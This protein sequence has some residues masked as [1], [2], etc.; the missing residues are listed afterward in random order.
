MLQGH[1]TLDFRKKKINRRKE[2]IPLLPQE[3]SA[4]YFRAVR[5]QPQKAS[6]DVPGAP[7]CSRISCPCPRRSLLQ[8]R[9]QEEHPVCTAKVEAVISSPS[10]TQKCTKQD[11]AQSSFGVASL[12]GSPERASSS[13]HPHQPDSPKPPSTHGPGR[14]PSEGNPSE[15][16]PSQHNA[17]HREGREGAKRPLPAQGHH[18][19]P[20]PPVTHRSLPREPGDSDISKS[21]PPL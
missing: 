7:R 2:N 8:C 5:G 4:V 9:M 12:A 21:P 15:A 1:F 13:P 19:A 11:T 3:I 20:Q 14:A 10:Q 6:A 17:K 18:A 16:P